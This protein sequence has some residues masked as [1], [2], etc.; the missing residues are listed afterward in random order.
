MAYKTIFLGP[1]DPIR[2]EAKAAAAIIPGMLCQFSAVDTC[3][4]HATGGGRCYA[5]VAIENDL[6]GKGIDDAYGT[7]DRVQLAVLK[8]GQEALMLI[9]NGEN[10]LLDSFLES[11]GDGYLRVV[12]ADP[13]IG[14]VVTGSIKFVA[15]EAVD[16][17][18][19]SAVDPS[20][21]I[22]VMAV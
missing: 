13:S 20:G 3:R 10:A 6:E 5:M 7:G 22:K 16:M 19:S 11:N 15:L 8:P 2:K 4:K 1:D 18:G 9:A 17:S 21:R 14:T 12:D